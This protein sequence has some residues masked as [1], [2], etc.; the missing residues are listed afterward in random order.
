VAGRVPEACSRLIRPDGREAWPGS[1]W[2]LLFDDYD[3][4]AFDIDPESWS[5]AQATSASVALGVTVNNLNVLMHR[6]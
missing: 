3:S 2:R 4:L 1:A 6:A 5:L